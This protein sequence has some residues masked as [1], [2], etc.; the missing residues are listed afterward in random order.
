MTQPWYTLE[1]IAVMTIREFAQL[2]GLEMVV[3][4]RRGELKSPSRFY[5]Q[6]KNAE[7]KG[8]GTLS[9]EYGNGNTPEAA[10]LDYIPHIELKTLAI[11]AYTDSRRDIQVPRLAALP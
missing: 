1:T 6:F 7:V 4:E 9:S 11:G 8:N 10:I 2:H 3:T 5:A